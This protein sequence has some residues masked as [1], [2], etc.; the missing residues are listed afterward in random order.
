MNTDK[1][2]L[3]INAVV[4]VAIAVVAIVVGLIVIRRQRGV[5][6]RV[7]GYVYASFWLCMALLYFFVA[8]RTVL[9]YLGYPSLDLIFFYVD[10]VFGGL[11]IPCA[12]F[13]F[14]Y[15]V[16]ANRN[17]AF[18]VSSIFLVV[19]VVWNI[20]NISAGAGNYTVDF[21][22]T[23]WEPNS[24]LAR[25]IAIFGLYIPGVVSMLGMNFA[26]LRAQSRVARYRILLTSISMV[27]A[28]SII[29]I[30]YLAPGPPWLR[31]VILIAALFGF[32]VYV[33]PKFLYRWLDIEEGS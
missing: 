12:V 24:A 6:I 33:P 26:L 16:T 29:I 18:L 13:L 27:V 9:G 5:R 3:L 4:S 10:N 14:M 21:W 22:Y 7:A 17:A 20:V 1:Y 2:G 25:A 28:I 23:E 19:W 15:F 32:F 11:M 8:L 31:L 30:D